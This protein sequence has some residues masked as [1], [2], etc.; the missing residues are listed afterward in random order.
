MKKIKIC[1][2]LILFGL[3]FLI[4]FGYDFYSN[5]ITSIFFPVNES[6]WEHMKIISTSILIYSIFEYTILKYKKIKF[7]NYILNIFVSSILSIIF[8]LIIFIPIYILIG[9]NM[10]IT[11]IILFITYIIS[12]IISY[13]ILKIKKIKYSNILSIFGLIV[14]YIVFGYLTY[15]PIHNFI[16][17][18]YDAEKYGINIY[19]I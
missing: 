4:H 6:I 18:D 9:H 3:S 7:E 12:A 10:I 8:Y 11:L 15:N 2:V 5:R 16:F 1:S 17:Y 13:Y 14:L 19:K